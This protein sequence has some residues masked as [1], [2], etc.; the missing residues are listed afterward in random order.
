MKNILKISSVLAAALM[1]AS[2][3]KMA[4]SKS[5]VEAGFEAAAV[6]PTLQVN[7]SSV[8][9]DYLNSM[10]IVEVTVSGMSEGVEVGLVSSKTEDF[11]S[12]YYVQAENA[13]DG[14]ITAKAKISPSSEWYVV[15]T[16]SDNASG[17][18]YSEVIKIDVPTFPFWASIAGTY[19]G[20]VES[21]AYGDSYTS[22]V[23][24][25]LDS[26]DPENKCY[27]LGFEPYY[28]DGGYPNTQSQFNYLEC[29]ID[30]ENNCIIAPYGSDMNLGGRW[31]HS[32]T[33][34]GACN[35]VFTFSKDYNSMVRAWEFYTVK[36]DGKVEDYYA[37][38][39]YK[40]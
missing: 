19:K 33:E 4:P 17:S 24:V 30:N 5:A 37:A 38:S 14:K 11:A 15:A 20:T 22:T 32:F 1:I 2:C 31:M 21:L 3:G 40:R 23:S 39:I 29:V 12:T 10:A 6:L 28:A 8:S 7:A 25:V 9:Y 35:G 34:K 27:I 13:A 36:P 26:E 16:A 18:S